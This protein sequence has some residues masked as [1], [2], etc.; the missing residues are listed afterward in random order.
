METILKK[1][2]KTIAFTCT[3]MILALFNYQIF[4]KEQILERGD[5]V[6]LELAPVDP[7]SLLQGDYMDLRYAI[8]NPQFYPDSLSNRGFLIIKLNDKRIGEFVRY[9]NEKK[10][11]Q[12]GEYAI[13]YFKKDFRINI[14][15]ESFFFQQ[16]KGYALDSAKFG[17]LRI[18]P[19]S[20]TSLLF[21]LA[22]K[23]LHII[24]LS[25]VEAKPI[26]KDA[27]AL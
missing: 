27:L 22:D 26:G 11:L 14:G 25:K 17:A 9:Q 1:Y 2:W 8:A 13:K 15:A 19:S 20:G 7:T 16:G 18:D 24:D 12:Q 6:F 10:P 3:I 21:G 5:L 23:N 4:Q